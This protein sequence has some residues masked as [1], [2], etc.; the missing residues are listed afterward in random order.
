MPEF[1]RK[2]RGE[3]RSPVE[4][5]AVKALLSDRILLYRLGVTDDHP[6][7][8]RWTERLEDLGEA[9]K[10]RVKKLLVIALLAERAIMQASREMD[11]GE[12]TERAKGRIK[13]LIRRFGNLPSKESE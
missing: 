10:E 6:G 8:E 5:A 13:Q 4:T 7:L 11:L 3:E 1:E 2:D 9:A 12:D